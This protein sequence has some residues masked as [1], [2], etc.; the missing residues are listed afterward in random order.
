MEGRTTKGP[1]AGGPFA[2]AAGDAGSVD[3][4]TDAP[5]DR[6][7]ALLGGAHVG[8]VLARGVRVD[9]PHPGVAVG[10]RDVGADLLVPAPVAVLA[11]LLVEHDL[12]VALAALAA[13]DQLAGE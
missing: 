5:R 9:V 8:V 6:R 7:L 2:C 11:A 13:A 1:P 3:R 10:L 12:A 4:G